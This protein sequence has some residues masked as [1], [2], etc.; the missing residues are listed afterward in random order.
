MLRHQTRTVEDGCRDFSRMRR[1]SAVRQAAVE[2]L[3][4]LRVAGSW[5][6]TPFSLLVGLG[7]VRSTEVV[8]TQSRSWALLGG[9][10]NRN[11]L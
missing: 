10:L 1:S 6:Q 11:G 5:R 7:E 4:F 9:P 2:A 8:G 3:R